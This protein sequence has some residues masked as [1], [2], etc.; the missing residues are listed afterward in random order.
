MYNRSVDPLQIL[1]GPLVGST[2]AQKRPRYRDEISAAAKRRRAKGDGLEEGS[3]RVRLAFRND[4]HAW[5]PVRQLGRRRRICFVNR[6]RRR[7]RQI[8]ASLYGIPRSSLLLP[9]HLHLDFLYTIL[10]SFVISGLKCDLRNASRKI[11]RLRAAFGSES[12]I[13]KWVVFSFVYQIHTLSSFT[14][15]SVMLFGSVL[16][17][18]MFS[19]VSYSKRV[20]LILL[21]AL[22]TQ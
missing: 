15:R 9:L 17:L 6:R 8:S 4:D 20:H 16:R 21:N 5:S 19:T 11:C 3:R 1:A 18:V 14:P 13:R 12:Y 2:A 10:D 22:R 7:F